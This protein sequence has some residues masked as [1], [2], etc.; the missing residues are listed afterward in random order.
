[1]AVR[2][3]LRQSQT[4]G[5]GAAIALFIAGVGVLAYDLW[6]TNHVPKET[7]TYYS[8]DDGKTYFEDS[9]YKFPPFDHNGKTAYRAV[10]YSSDQGKFVGYLYRLK[11]SAQKKLQDAYAKAGGN[12]QAL[13]GVDQLMGSDQIRFAGTQLKRPGDTDWVN[14]SPRPPDVHSPGGTH[15]FYQIQP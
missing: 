8:D 9:I 4:I 13:V 7:T 2:E 11:P 10:V 3:S 14:A 5:V 12:Q 1:M 15:S 6:P